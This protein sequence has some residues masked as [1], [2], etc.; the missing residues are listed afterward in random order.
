M[1][2]APTDIT[3]D[4]LQVREN[5]KDVT[6]GRIRIL[7]PDTNADYNCTLSSDEKNQLEIMNDNKTLR[8]IKELDFENERVKSFEIK[9]KDKKKDSMS[10]TKQFDLRIIDVN[11]APSAGCEN[12]LYISQQETLGTVLG[13][14][15][16][17]DPDNINSRDTCKP[18][19]KLTYSVLSE[20]TFPF[21]ILDGFLVKTGQIE[22]NKTYIFR[23]SVQDDGNLFPKNSGHVRTKTTAFNCTV[24]S[25]PVIG[26]QVTLS[27]NQIEE[28]SSNGSI[29]GY[30]GMEGKEEKKKYDME[31]ELMKD[32][33]NNYPFVIEGN[34]LMLMLSVYGGPRTD[35]DYTIPQHVMVMVR[36]NDTSRH[37]TYT[38][39][40]I[41]I[42][43]K[44][45]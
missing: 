28:G 31:Y 44:K 32:E 37:V 34:K 14:L 6:I 5:E 30:L 38:R 42:E 21:K 3:I 1:N 29:I 40:A 20:G 7:D 26:S 9:C 18:K 25:R 2:E 16:V 12:P 27:S 4:N 36:A 10:F 23:V 15:N 22:I 45:C 11:E 19:Q 13:N 33:C 35:Q 8:L 24:I 41:F 43:G 39:F 17:T